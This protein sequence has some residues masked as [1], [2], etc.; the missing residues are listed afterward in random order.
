M[1]ELIDGPLWQEFSGAFARVKPADIALTETLRRVC[2]GSQLRSLFQPIYRAGSGELEGC[3][4]LI[5]L[6]EDS[7]LLPQD[8]FAEAA[9]VGLL[10]ALESASAAQHLEAVKP[11]LG[12]KRLFLNFSAPL[13]ADARFGTS[14][15]LDRTHALGLPASQ[16]VL[17]IPEI[18]RIRDL[19]SF[20]RYLEPFRREGFKIAVDDFGAGYT[21]LRMITDLSPDF[22]KVDRVFID[23]IASHA[24]KRVLVESVVSLCHRVNCLVIAEGI[25]TAAELETCLSAGVDFLQG[26]LFAGPLDVREAFETPEIALPARWHIPSADA[27]DE[28]RAFLA[29]ETAVEVSEPPSSAAA[30]FADEPSLE[31]L[32]VVRD[33]AIHGLLRRSDLPALDGTGGSLA[34][35]ASPRFDKVSEL[36][37]LSR[38]AEAVLRRPAERRYDP[39]VV[40]GPDRAYRGLLTVEALLGAL[41]RQSA[42]A[43]LQVNPVT[44]LPGRFALERHLADR[45]ASHRPFSLLRLNLLRF[46]LF[47]DRYGFS[48]GDDLLIQLATLVREE[49]DGDDAF[50]AHLADDDFAVAGPSERAEEQAKRLLAGFDDA[51]RGLYDRTDAEAGMFRVPDRLGQWREVPLIGLAGGLV[52]WRDD[53]VLGVRT[54][55]EAAESTLRGARQAGTTNLLVNRRSLRTA[56]RLT[57]PR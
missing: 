35:V 46:R 53:E 31:I 9:R 22:V 19:A 56:S 26:F 54:L 45:L 6:P 50:V 47:N 41:A 33:G 34:S 32:P 18:L 21:N 1:S 38:V 20:A 49:M 2:A 48:R 52:Q 4:A 30:R 36:E 51:T 23:G 3:E 16:I 11:H 27:R 25:E 28:A 43:A 13:F 42:A 55:M 8:A 12:E 7:K 17:E 37:P 24:R 44:Q 10:L 39:L 57:A 5:R 15:L 14:W 40:V 29:A